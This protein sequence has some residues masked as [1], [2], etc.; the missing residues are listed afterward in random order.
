[1]SRG[2]EYLR[3]KINDA[4]LQAVNLNAT[5]AGNEVG[6]FVR[7]MPMPATLS[8]TGT[9]T[10]GTAVTI[11]LPAVAARFHYITHLVIRRFAAALLTAAATPVVVTT[12]NLPGTLAFSIDASAAAQGTI[13]EHVYALPNPL[14]SSVV[15]TDTTIVAPGTTSTIWRLTA[16]Y[17]TGT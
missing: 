6:V 12:T 5:P 17:Y 16:F 1:M 3:V 7:N 14:K 8:V 2:A 13:H 10:S 9:A 4:S 15:N 11:T